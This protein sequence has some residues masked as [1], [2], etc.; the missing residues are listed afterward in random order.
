MACQGTFALA[1]RFAGAFQAVQI[2][3]SC[4][5]GAEVDLAEESLLF[6]LMQADEIQKA[7]PD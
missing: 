5:I 4:T 7:R 3:K 6:L 1:K 2:L